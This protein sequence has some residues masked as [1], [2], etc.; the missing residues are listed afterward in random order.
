MIWSL[1]DV[2][3]FR[4]CTFDIN[5]TF[6]CPRNYD[7]ADSVCSW[8]SLRLV[9]CAILYGQLPPLPAPIRWKARHVRMT[10]LGASPQGRSTSFWRRQI[11]LTHAGHEYKRSNLRNDSSIA[12]LHIYH[13]FN[14]PQPFFACASQ[15]LNF[16]MPSR[17]NGMFSSLFLTYFHAD[18]CV[19]TLTLTAIL[20]RLNHS[21]TTWQASSESTGPC[22]CIMN[23]NARADS[24]LW[25]GMTRS[26][27]Q[28]TTPSGP[29]PFS[30]SLSGG[31]TPPLP[32]NV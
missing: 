25:A 31:I 20:W 13:P 19:A 22:N 28:A 17:S 11:N 24:V 3:S 7:L 27:V 14:P 10:Y 12:I 30:V 1:G 15:H 4:Y 26:R 16:F 23:C 21:N 9:T 2:L 18:V 32:L 5:K 29:R 6:R 8:H